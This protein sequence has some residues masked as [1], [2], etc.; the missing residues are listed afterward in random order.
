[1]VC[2][3]CSVRLDRWRLHEL[4]IGDLLQLGRIAVVVVVVVVRISEVAG[5]RRRYVGP[6]RA[7]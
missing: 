2:D 6:R 7:R 3:D 5:R 1:L 4:V